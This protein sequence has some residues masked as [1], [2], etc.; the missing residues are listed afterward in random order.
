MKIQDLKGLKEELSD[1]N[2][3]LSELT[4]ELNDT[5]NTIRESLVLTSDTINEMSKSFTNA[6]KEAMDKMSDMSI[7]MNIRDTVLKNLGLDSLL[8][9]FLKKK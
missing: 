7:Q 8:P 9:D 5:K 1:M 4:R 3:N 2:K 6:L